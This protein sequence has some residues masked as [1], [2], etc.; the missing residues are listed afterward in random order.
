MKFNLYLSEYNSMVESENDIV[1]RVDA[2]LHNIFPT[3][4]FFI[5]IR[6]TCSESVSELFFIYWGVKQQEYMEKL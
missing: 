4:V 5:L 1:I 3:R 6:Q 2:A